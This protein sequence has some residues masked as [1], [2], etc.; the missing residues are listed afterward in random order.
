MAN[1][2]VT[3]L[4]L[5]LLGFGCS[6]VPLLVRVPGPASEWGLHGV[7][8]AAMGS[9]AVVGM[10]GPSRLPLV[11]FLLVAAAWAWHELPRR[12]EQ[13][14][15]AVDLLA[16]ALLLL[17]VPRHEEIAAQVEHVHGG[18]AAGGAVLPVLVGLFW[19]GM[20][21]GC[22]LQAAGRLAVRDSLSSVGMI[23]SMTL[24][25]LL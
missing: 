11:G 19:L 20:H 1:G 8:A 25:A 14:H 5:G 21:G 24:M 2:A 10:D 17:F 22:L 4:L 7:M 9:M 16:M 6:L 18:V 3:H 23:G 13:L 15:V 12:R